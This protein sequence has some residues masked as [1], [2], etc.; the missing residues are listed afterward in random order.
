MIERRAT[1][2]IDPD[3]FPALRFYGEIRL[4]YPARAR[5]QLPTPPIERALA[6][7]A[8]RDGRVARQREKTRNQ[9][10][11][12]LLKPDIH[13]QG[14]LGR[15]KIDTAV[16]AA[17]AALLGKP[18][19]AMDDVIDF[20]I[21]INQK[22]Q[23]RRL[24]DNR[25]SDYYLRN[26]ETGEADID[27]QRGKAGGALRLFFRRRKD[28]LPV[29]LQPCRRDGVDIEC[30][31]QQLK[32]GPGTLDILDPQ[33]FALRVSQANVHNREVAENI[34]FQRTQL[35]CQAVRVIDRRLDL[36]DQ[37][38]PPAVGLQEKISAADQQDSNHDRRQNYGG[39]KRL[40]CH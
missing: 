29:E 40:A 14:F 9:P 19:L 23:I 10:A 2:K 18:D 39:D 8:C 28:G 4:E 15:I 16:K 6:D 3:F 7:D 12:G 1:V 5:L 26:L 21:K 31:T 37:Q 38:R 20:C 30:A 22:A 35:D 17:I 34:P 25:L 27:R 11:L 36:G 33:P 24:P 13:R 32:R